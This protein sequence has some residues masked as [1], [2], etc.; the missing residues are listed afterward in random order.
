V[1]KATLREL[2][3]RAVECL[4]QLLGC[5]D[6]RIRL[7]AATAILDRHLGSRRTS[8]CTALRRTV[9]LRR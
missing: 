5:A 1:I 2:P 6:E 9:T 3:P 4:G 7:E 8:A